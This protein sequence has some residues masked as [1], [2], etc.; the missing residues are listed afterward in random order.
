[1]IVLFNVILLCFLT[2]EASA[3]DTS[4]QKLNEDNKGHA[5]EEVG[6]PRRPQLYTQK[7]HCRQLNIADSSEILFPRDEHTNWLYIFIL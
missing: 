7:K 6:D 1:M 3:I 2:V 5:N 4:K